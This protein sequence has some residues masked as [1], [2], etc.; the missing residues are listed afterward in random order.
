MHTVSGE[1]K[2]GRRRGRG[3]RR[4]LSARGVLELDD[5]A[6]GNAAADE[7]GLPREAP[8]IRRAWVPALDDG[9][10]QGYNQ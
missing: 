7:L 8:H 6:R 1:G 5:Q 2:S 10:K 4:P 9:P 3:A